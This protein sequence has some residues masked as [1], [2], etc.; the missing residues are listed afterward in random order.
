MAGWLGWAWGKSLL[1]Y[2]SIDFRTLTY[3][4]L[5]GLDQGT[6]SQH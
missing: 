4:G 3:G 1:T 5:V 6:N 2:R